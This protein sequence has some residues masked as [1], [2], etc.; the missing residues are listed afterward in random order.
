MPSTKLSFF[1][2]SV[3][4]DLS[5]EIL[6]AR[7]ERPGTAAQQPTSRSAAR[8]SPGDLAG[9]EGEFAGGDCGVPFCKGIS[10]DICG[11]IIYYLVI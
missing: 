6:L 1:L 7:Q 3:S 5:Q 2:R 8:R 11:T 9:G 4:V 10:W